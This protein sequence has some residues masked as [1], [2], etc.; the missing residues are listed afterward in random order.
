M[1][2][3]GRVRFWPEIGPLRTPVNQQSLTQDWREELLKKFVLAHLAGRLE[4]RWE[5]DG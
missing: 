1:I 5:V 3:V 4:Q 2:G